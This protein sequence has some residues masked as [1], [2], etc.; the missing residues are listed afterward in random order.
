MAGTY[1]LE[2]VKHHLKLDEIDDD[3]SYLQFLMEVAAAYVE[4][5]VGKCDT[6]NPK[7]VLLLLV[8][9]S[10]LY[11]NRQY[12]IDKNNEKVQY[13]TQSI[14]LQLQLEEVPEDDQSWDS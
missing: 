1:S 3:D 2:L 6:E 7:V 10:N 5:A 14:L 13:V 12:T 4:D 9:I 8:L 11:E